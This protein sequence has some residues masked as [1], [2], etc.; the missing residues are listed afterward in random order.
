MLLRSSVILVVVA[1]LAVSGSIGRSRCGNSCSG[2]DGDD[3]SRLTGQWSYTLFNGVTDKTFID[4]WIKTNGSR[5][6][7]GLRLE[8]RLAAGVGLR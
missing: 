3:C 1:I 2:D 8:L 6:A 7:V 5:S 4:K